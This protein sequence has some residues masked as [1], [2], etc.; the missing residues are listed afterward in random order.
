MAATS[1]GSVTSGRTRSSGQNIVIAG[2]RTVSRRV[3]R[4]HSRSVR[5]LKVALPLTALATVAISAVIILKKVHIGAA[6]AD[7][8][9]PQIVADNLKMQNPH[10]EGFN[11]DGGRYWV[12]AQSAQQDLKSLTVVRLDG[13]TGELTDANK[14]KTNLS[15][16]RGLYDTKAGVLELYDQITV[17]GDGGLKADLTRASIKTKEGIVSSDQPSTVAMQAGEINANQMT[18]RQKTKEYTF[19]DSVRMHLKPKAPAENGAAAAP[20][21]LPFGKT[22]EPIDVASNRLDV[23][24]DK[25]TA[26]FTGRVVAT[27]AGATMTSPEMTVTYEG[28]VAGQGPGAAKSADGATTGTKLK[29]IIAR[30][31]VVLE[32]ASGETATSRTAVF[33]AE[34]ET[35][36]LEGDVVLNQGTDKRAVGDRAEYDQAAQTLVL[37]GPVTVTQGQNIIKG[38]RLAYDR[39]SGKMHLTSPDGPAAGRISA[40]FVRTA[41]KAAATSGDDDQSTDDAQSSDGI[42]FGGSFKTDPKAPFDLVADKLDVDDTAK[43]AVFTGNVVATQGDS[44]IRAQELTAYYTGNASIASSTDPAGAAAALTHLRAKKKVS[45]VSKDGQTAT[46]DWVEVDVKKNLATLG[47]AVV[48]TQGKNIV[49]GTKVD[50]DMNTGQATIKT[51][52]A[53]GVGGAMISS[54]DGDGTGQIIKADRPSAVFYPGELIGSKSKSKA[55]KKDVDG[56]QVRTSP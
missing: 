10:Y 17:T 2:D 31:S 37:T 18:I 40:H 34:A 50:I 38:R 27:Q 9:M 45:I 52:P 5:I 1:D 33:D 7:L 13:I 39:T 56:W 51:E 15:A 22:G 24:D 36:V 53:S 49:K 55:A 35:A 54:S 48:L 3:A 46:G 42:S 43:A 32:Q 4:R 14:K 26:L 16:K 19:V 6:I 23:D 29:L 44:T 47:G 20:N 28:T 25:K 11:A 21:P 30:D 12:K 8:P 41:T